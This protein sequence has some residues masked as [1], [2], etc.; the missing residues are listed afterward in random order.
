M[1]NGRI[2]KASRK[3]VDGS[4]KQGGWT[5]HWDESYDIEYDGELTCTVA[6]AIIAAFVASPEHIKQSGSSYGALRWELADSDIRVLAKSRQLLVTR[7][8]GLCD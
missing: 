7:G 4:T 1:F 6:E 5:D 3:M 2:I 8:M